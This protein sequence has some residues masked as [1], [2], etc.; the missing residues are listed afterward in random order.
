MS[1]AVK[2]MTIYPLSFPLKRKVSHA[3]SQR[4]VSAPIVVSIELMNGAVGHGETLPRDYVT[5]ETNTSVIELLQGEFLKELL[6]FTPQNFPEALEAIEALPSIAEDGSPCPAA[7]ACV[8][9][10]LLDAVMRSQDR[11]MDDVVGWQGNAHLGLPGSTRSCRFSMVLASES[12]ESIR[13]TATLAKWAGFRH[14]KLKVGMQN[15]AARMNALLRVI[16]RLLSRDRATLRLDAN[17]AWHLDEAV[18]ALRRWQDVPISGVEQ[19]LHPS[20][21]G[22]LVKLKRRC[23]VQIFHD[24]SLSS[25]DD[26]ER[27]FEMGVADGFNIRVSKC[28]GLL[29]SVRL[30]AFALK[31]GIDVQLGCMVG[32]TSILSAAGVRFLQ[33]IPKVRFAEGSFGPLLSAYDVTRKRVR[34]GWGGRLPTIGSA[35]LGVEVAADLLETHTPDK[36]IMIEL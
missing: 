31:R 12:V 16:S 34:F 14:F 23:D 15:D 25:M 33:T 36:P 24:E 8:E 9:L 19:P 29:S 4:S 27:L 26:A 7:R 22:D 5:G 10:A 17:G 35:G 21:D 11:T 30:A 18:V 2:R 6:A 3:T 13:R 20:N 32:E 1:L 28:G